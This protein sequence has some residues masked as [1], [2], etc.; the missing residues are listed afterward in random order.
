MVNKHNQVICDLTKTILHDGV[1]LYPGYCEV[2]DGILYRYDSQDPN[3]EIEASRD[4][5]RGYKPG[6][7][8]HRVKYQYVAVEEPCTDEVLQGKHFMSKK[9]LEKYLTEHNQ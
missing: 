4:T 5:R 3:N 6:M 7:L 1:T 9:A 8:H 2:K